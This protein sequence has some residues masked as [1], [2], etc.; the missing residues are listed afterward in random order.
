MS[1]EHRGEWIADAIDV[2]VV[3]ENNHIRT[4]LEVSHAGND[5][6]TTHIVHG[7]YEN[8]PPM[9]TLAI[10]DKHGNIVDEGTFEEGEI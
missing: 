4:V 3:T 9:F 7:E 5:G 1:T 2:L 8:F 10:T 6:I